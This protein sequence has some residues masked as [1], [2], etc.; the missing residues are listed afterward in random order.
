MP[1]QVLTKAQFRAQFET[2][3]EIAFNLR[4]QMSVEGVVC[5]YSVFRLLDRL[6]LEDGEQFYIHARPEDGV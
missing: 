3:V 2:P 5:G 6:V 1:C 4:A